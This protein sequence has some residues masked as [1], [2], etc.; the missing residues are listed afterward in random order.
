MKKSEIFESF[1]KIAQNQ[2]L[3]THADK[4]DKRWDSLSIEQ[5]GKLY[6]IKS[7]L[8]EDMKYDKNIMEDAHPESVIISPSYDKLNGLVENEIEGQNIRAR[9]TMKNPNGQSTHHKYAKQQL[10]LSLVRVA[11]DLD[12]KNQE[13]LYKLAD[14]CLLQTTQSNKIIKKALFPLL[15]G[16]S[17]AILGGI[18]LKNHTKFHSDGFQ[19]DYQKAISEIDDLLNSNS[20][21]G[22]GYNYRPEFLK[23]VHDLKDKLQQFNTSYQSLMPILDKMDTPKTGKELLELAQKPETQNTMEQIKIFKDSAINLFPYIKK[24][25]Q[26]FSNETY[27]NRQ[28]SDKGFLSKLVDSVPGLH[29]GANLIADDFDDVVH[30][31]QTVLSDITGIVKNLQN[32]NSIEQSAKQELQ[33]SASEAEKPVTKPATE[34]EAPWADLE[35]ELNSGL[36]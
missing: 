31:L 15:I 18:Y 27:K 13:Q 4:K 35:K 30:A 19:M 1:A 34:D 23:V 29:G 32:S 3:I 14:F 17:A 24:I 11:N 6:N 25:I 12:N 9:I 2:N 8:P 22:V 28:I 5:I 10:L 7:D 21:Y 16:I 36:K 26:D 20:N 33:Q